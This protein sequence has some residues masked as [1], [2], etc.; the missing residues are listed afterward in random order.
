MKSSVLLLVPSVFASLPNPEKLKLKL[1]EIAQEQ[2]DYYNCSFSIAVRDADS[3]MQ[4]AAGFADF[5]QNRK[6]TTSDG[7]AW[8]SGTKPLTGASI[9][10][11]VGE[12]KFGLDDVAYPLVD[13][14]LAKM[15]KAHPEQNFSSMYDLWGDH[16]K[17]VTVMSLLDMKAGVPDFDTANCRKGGICADPLRAALYANPSK[18]YS[19]T[20]L[21]NFDWVRGKWEAHPFYSSTNFMV[22]GMILA[23]DAGVDNWND[24][25]QAGFLPADLKDKLQFAKRGAPTDYTPVHGYDRTTYNTPNG[26]T[27][28]ID[29]SAVDG[30]FAGWTASDV[31][32]SPAAMADLTWAVYG[33]DPS[34]APPE[35]AKLMHNDGTSGHGYGVATFNMNSKT[36]QSSSSAYGIAY[37]HLGATYGYNSLIMYAPALNIALSVGTNLETDTQSHTGETACF[38]YSAIASAFLDQNITCTR[39]SVD[40]SWGKQCECTPIKSTVIV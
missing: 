8:G 38:A 39:P 26:T 16:V 2:A 34:I 36:G 18:A 31:V 25:D 15:A 28:N 24:F 7:F 22:L 35:L 37:G 29:V 5:T 9:L 12:G 17:N 19:P 32:A 23:N 1:Q 6:I 27:V 20:E 4:A 14:F 21:M 11:L 30:C 33:P 40:G 3:A 10:K 13:P